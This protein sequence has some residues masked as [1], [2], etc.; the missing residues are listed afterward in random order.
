MA[1]KRIT[2]TLCLW[3]FVLIPWTLPARG[4]P[5]VSTGG[6]VTVVAADSQ[7]KGTIV[8][9]TSAA[10]LLRS[11][12]W[13]DSWERLPF[14]AEL[15]STLH[16][17]AID[18]TRPNVYLVGVTSDN[19]Q[20][21][22]VYRSVDGGASWVQLP[23]VRRKQVWSLAY[24][25]ADSN[26]IAAG[27][28]DGVYLTHDGGE[29]WAQISS[30]DSGGPKPVVALAF[31]PTSPR[32]LYAGTPHLSWKTGDGGTT[33]RALRRG[34]EEDS[35]IFSIAVD[36]TRPRRLFAGA[37]S[38][39]YRSLDAGSNWTS[40]ERAV[41]AQFRTYIIAA[42]PRSS[43]IFVAGTNAGILKSLDG[44]VT[45]RK[46]S[47]LATRSIAFHVSDPR[48][49]IVATDQGILRSDDGGDHFKLVAT[50]R[51]GVLAATAILK[52]GDAN[53]HLRR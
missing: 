46:I 10:V 38:G 50:F 34:M 43:N 42:Q 19:S 35:D 52:P 14:P 6:P 48:Q 29:N 4:E 21:A 24:W 26:V 5:P 41:G 51:G 44:G 49:L 2:I 27:T 45:W 11:R 1:P 28:Q 33:W 15:R 37:C 39:L 12:D 13:A 22:G 16:A 32:T 18:P 30:L 20:Y 25:P 3:T 40:L 47:S 31:D 36:N 23:G 17:I 53:R 7:Q 9:G 8:A